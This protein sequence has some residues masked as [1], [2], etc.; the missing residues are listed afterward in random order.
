MFSIL[1]RFFNQQHFNNKASVA[2]ANYYRFASDS[3]A[4]LKY[5]KRVHGLDLFVQNNLSPKQLGE[6]ESLIN[7]SKHFLDL[8]CGTGDFTK[9]LEAKFKNK[10]SAI[11]MALSAKNI[12][13]TFKKTNFE[14]SSLGEARFD[15]V[16]SFDGFYMLNNIEGTLS[17][18]MNSLKKKG[19]FALTYTSKEEIKKTKLYKAIE[20]QNLKLDIADFT[21]DDKEFNE[22]AFEALNELEEDFVSEGNFNIFKTKKREIDQNLAAHNEKKMFRYLLKISK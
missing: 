17:K 16:V 11:D 21:Q 22:K 7:K 14:R 10:A 12:G 3:E 9:Y 5:C 2:F 20:K 13:N 4:M 15:L 19:V 8:G 6:M 1:K 18:V